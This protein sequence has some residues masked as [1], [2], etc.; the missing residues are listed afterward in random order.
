MKIYFSFLFLEVFKFETSFGQT[1]KLL[2]EE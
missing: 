1:R 2:L